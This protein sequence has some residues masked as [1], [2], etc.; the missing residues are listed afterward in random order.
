MVSSTL[1][2]NNMSFFSEAVKLFDM[3][4][5]GKNFLPIRTTKFVKSTLNC[6]GIFYLQKIG[7]HRKNWAASCIDR[8]C[9]KQR[10]VSLAYISE[11]A[12]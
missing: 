5:Q 8:R 2:S 6:S 10:Y 12:I 7:L 3:Y 9:V 1:Q 4:G 11:E